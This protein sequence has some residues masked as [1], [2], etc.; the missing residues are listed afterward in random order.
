MIAVGRSKSA[1]SAAN[2]SDPGAGYWTSCSSRGNPPKSW[3]VGGFSIA[4]T[5]VFGT[6]QWAE[7]LR[8]TRGLA[9]SAAPIADHPFV[10]E[11]RDSAFI[12]FPCPTN[13]A[14]IRVI[15]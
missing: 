10:Y 15:E 9:G 3:I 5:A 4:V 12:G 11:L 2:S 14:G 7:M 1:T 13:T 6:Y 8:T